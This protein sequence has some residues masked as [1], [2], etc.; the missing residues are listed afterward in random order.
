[1]GAENQHC[2]MRHFFYGL[3][4]NSPAAPQLLHNVSVVHDLVVHINRRTVC[5][6]RQFDYIHCAHHAGA[7]AS[8]PYPQQ[9]FSICG[10]LHCCPK[11]LISEDS[12]IP[13]GLPCLHP[14]SSWSTSR[15]STRRT[16]L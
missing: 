6:Q 2:A 15:N 10:G 5:F 4:K 8:R 13:H 16:S 11:C 3:H 14:V 7:E 9:N 1:M 12:I